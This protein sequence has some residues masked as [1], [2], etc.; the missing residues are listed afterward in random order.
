MERYLYT[1]DE[2]DNRQQQREYDLTSILNHPED[3]SEEELRAFFSQP[4]NK[5]DYRLYRL[6]QMAGNRDRV[7][8]PDA[9]RAW[10]AFKRDEIS[11]VKSARKLR[12][13]T[14][15]AA[16]LGAA[17]VCLVLL[18]YHLVFGTSAND[19][20]SLVAMVYDDKPQVVVLESEGE[21]LESFTQKD[22]IS[23]FSPSSETVA[24]AAATEAP[25]K[26]RTLS[27]PRGVDFKITLPDGT[28][29]WLNAESSLQ[30]P[31]AFTSDVRKVILTGEAYFKV[32]RNEEAPFIVE[33]DKMGI[34]VLGTEFNFRNYA[35]EKPLVALID[36]SISI[37]PSGA[38]DEHIVLKPGQGACVESDGQISVLEEVDTYGVTQWVSGYFYFQ[39]QPLIEILQD[40]GRWYNVGVV[41]ENSYYVDEKMHF[42]SLR[43]ASLEQTID[44]LNRLQKARVALEGNNIIVR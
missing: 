40:L 10:E 31:A 25:V 8:S 6:A 38:S 15:G 26:M 13:H 4:E 19:G 21:Q 18:V 23:F 29:V 5:A 32:A 16:L 33:T 22:S 9:G 37:L 28:E 34:K 24:E 3:Y 44:N 30:F 11:P 2:T 35:S 42:S 41:F 12:W 27:T 7:P 43:S 17:A 1:M 39:N 36:G 14:W 20:Q